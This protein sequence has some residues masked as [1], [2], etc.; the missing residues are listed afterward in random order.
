[1]KANLTTCPTCGSR[2]LAHLHSDFTLRARQKVIVVPKLDRYECQRCG[3][4]LF[5]YDG[6]KRI[7]EARQPRRK[8][9]KSA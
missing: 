3:E 1:M 8:L 2:K 5:D 9:S 7:E 6:I 4:V